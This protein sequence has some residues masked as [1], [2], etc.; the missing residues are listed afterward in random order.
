MQLVGYYLCNIILFIHL[1]KSFLL[2]K[3]KWLITCNGVCRAGCAQPPRPGAPI[4]GG[5][6]DDRRRCGASMSVFANRRLG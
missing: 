6:T 5:L 4:F 2:K 1:C 3:K